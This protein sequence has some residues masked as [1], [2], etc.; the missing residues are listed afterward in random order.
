LEILSTSALNGAFALGGEMASK[1]LGFGVN[2]YTSRKA[3]MLVHA[4]EEIKQGLFEAT[5][6]R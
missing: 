5:G 1:V 4:G 6:S 3:G 2:K